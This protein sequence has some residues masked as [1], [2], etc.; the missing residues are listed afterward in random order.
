[1]IRFL[2]GHLIN[3]DTPHTPQLTRSKPSRPLVRKSS[4]KAIHLHYIL[5]QS[6]WT[7]RC[8]SL[9]RAVSCSG[10]GRARPLFE[11]EGGIYW[12]GACLRLSNLPTDRGKQ[13]SCRGPLAKWQSRG[14]APRNRGAGYLHLSL[15]A[16]GSALSNISCHISGTYG[17]LLIHSGSLE[18]P[19][20]LIFGPPRLRGAVPGNLA[21]PNL[22]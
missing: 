6:R 20:T 7:R 13:T 14:T 19:T 11:Q 10:V 3:H 9:A 2:R 18:G 17:K 16:G 22:R 15:S 4:Y 8:R 21:A 12:E 1:M 5:P